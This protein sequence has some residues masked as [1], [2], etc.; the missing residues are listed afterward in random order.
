MNR[1][2]GVLRSCLAISL[3]LKS[4]LGDLHQHLQRG[5]VVIL[6]G[7]RKHNRRDAFLQQHW[8]QQNGGSIVD[9]EARDKERTEVA[10]LRANR[11]DFGDDAGGDAVRAIHDRSLEIGRRS[12]SLAAPAH[13]LSAANNQ[14]SAR[15]SDSGDGGN[16]RLQGLRLR[17]RA[18]NERAAVAQFGHLSLL[19]RWLA[20]K[21]RFHP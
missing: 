21:L 18:N 5:Q 12:Q 10:G 9:A 7:N 11:S 6:R 13:G 17:A 2:G 8:K 4:K 1:R 20:G 19:R 14:Q 15:G 3:Q 16:Q